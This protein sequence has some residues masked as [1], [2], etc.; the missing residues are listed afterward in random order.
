MA[1][2]GSFNAGFARY[3]PTAVLLTLLLSGGSLLLLPHSYG[4]TASQAAVAEGRSLEFEVVSI[5]ANR[6]GNPGSIFGP[7]RGDRVSYTN[8]TLKTLIRI[9]YRVQDFLISGGPGWLSSERYDVN[10]KFENP[11]ITPPQLQQMLQS[12]L[13]KRFTLVVHRET[14]EMPIY[15]LVKSREDGKLGPRLRDSSNQSCS[16]PPS[17]GEGKPGQLPEPT[18]GQ[19]VY[20]WG[21]M[22]GIRTDLSAL[23]AV[24]SGIVS[25]TVVDHTGLNGDFDLNLEWAPDDLTTA[26]GADAAAPAA[27]VPSISTA[28]QE[29]LGLK[30]N[31]QKGPVEVLV[32]DKAGKAAESDN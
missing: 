8:V 30:L 22:K 15:A 17:S 28:L 20:D 1:D 31:S 25:R 11:G 10:A 6:S 18:C 7:P 4:Q 27:G 21:Q 5:K 9:A 23:S 3:L 19:I 24:L 29:Q 32:V 2:H 26:N 12:M 14:K 13:E 16:S